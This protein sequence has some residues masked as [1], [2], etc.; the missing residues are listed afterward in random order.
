MLYLTE[1]V[2]M[3]DIVYGLIEK[4]KKSCQNYSQN[5]FLSGPVLILSIFV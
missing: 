5:P 3:R 1:V 4:F 2:L